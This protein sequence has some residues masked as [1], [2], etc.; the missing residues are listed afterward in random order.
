ML[1]EDIVEYAVARIQEKEELPDIGAELASHLSRLSQ[2]LRASPSIP[3]GLLE[4]ELYGLVLLLDSIPANY[5]LP[6][7]TSLYG[8]P[9]GN[10]ICRYIESTRDMR[11]R[12]EF[13]ER[14][15]SLLDLF[16][17]MRL[18]RIRQTLAYI[19][20]GWGWKNVSGY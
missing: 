17:E 3:D 8:H 18:A 15:M 2:C 13:L 11:N 14:L 7:V 16:S 4:S 1:N 5:S 6:F 9:V 19:E 10:V 20:E 12:M